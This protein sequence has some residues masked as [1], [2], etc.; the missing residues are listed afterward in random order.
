MQHERSRRPLVVGNLVLG[1]LLVLGPAAGTR[2]VPDVL[3]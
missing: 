1:N 2:G 3:I